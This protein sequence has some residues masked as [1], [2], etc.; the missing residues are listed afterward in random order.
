MPKAKVIVDACCY[1]S[2]ANLPGRPGTGKCA[3]GVLI[4]DEMGNEHERSQYLGEMTVP[5][6]EF[7]GL[8]FALDQTAG[9]T[10]FD[11]EVWMDSELVVNWM[12]G[13]YRL[14]KEHIRPLFDE[15]KKNTQRFKSV[16]FFHHSK[17]S[18][19]AKKSHRLAELEYRKNQN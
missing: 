19:L 12:T 5:E 11:I 13:R 18:Q 8:I 16:D 10:R 6:A 3:C 17:N 4:M 9:I 15:A 2:N 7:R 1:V 14:R